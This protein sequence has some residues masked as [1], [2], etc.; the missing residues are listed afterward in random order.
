MKKHFTG[1]FTVLLTI[2]GISLLSYQISD[3]L[4]RSSSK[5]I[6]ER[7]DSLERRI[8]TLEQTLDIQSKDL[9]ILSETILDMDPEIVFDRNLFLFK[10]ALI[11]VESGF[12]RKAVNGQ[13]GAGG[14]YQ[15]LPSN[16]FM[17]ESNRLLGY[18]E[19]SDSCRFDPARSNLMYEIVNNHHNPNRCIDR[20]IFLH[21]PRAGEW[22]RQRVLREYE[23]FIKIA[24]QLNSKTK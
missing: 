13:T 6:L 2:L 19:F 10:L 3:M 18:A 21:N 5:P 17:D 12:D 8:V 7:M 9:N 24:L 20:S 22:Y 1:F 23:F 11:K 14:I 4:D 15:I 16:G